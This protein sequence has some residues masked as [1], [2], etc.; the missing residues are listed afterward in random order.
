[1]AKTQNGGKHKQRIGGLDLSPLRERKVGMAKAAE[2]LDLS[3][4]GQ[5]APLLEKLNPMELVQ[6]VMSFIGLYMKGADVRLHLEFQVREKKFS[7][8]VYEG[9]SQ[10]MVTTLVDM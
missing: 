9:E 2:G 8:S 1:M 6:L 10:V 4:M 7:V 5:F 3:S